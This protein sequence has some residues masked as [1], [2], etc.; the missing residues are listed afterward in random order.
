MQQAQGTDRFSG[1]GPPKKMPKDIFGPPERIPSGR[2]KFVPFS[3]TPQKLDPELHRMAVEKMADLGRQKT[4]E[5]RKREMLDRRD[6][7]RRAMR[8]GGAQGDVVPLGRRKRETNPVVEN[9]PR[10][11]PRP[12]GLIRA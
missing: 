12:S 9:K 3:G 7:L 10:R 8:R 5:T 6:D 11:R 4:Q 2:D 1:R